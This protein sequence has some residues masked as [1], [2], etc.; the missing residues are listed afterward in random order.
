VLAKFTTKFLR[1]MGL[2]FIFFFAIFCIFGSLFLRD[3][4]DT[5]FLSK[6]LEYT[7]SFESRFYDY[8]MREQLNRKA[9]SKDVALIKI[10]DASLEKIGM[11][12]I[13]RSIHADMI[14][15]LGAFGAKVVA[16]D[17]LYPEKAPVCGPVSPDDILAEA[18]SNF[19][20]DGGKVFLAYTTGTSVEDSLPEAPVEMLNDTVVTRSSSDVNMHAYQIGR[21]TFP[22]QKFVEADVGLGSIS[23]SEDPD[24]IFRHYL[25]ILNVDTIYFGSLGFNSWEAF[26][27]KK[28]EVKIF[29][30]GTGELELDD[31]RL[32][33]NNRGETKIRWFGNVENFANVSL[34]ELLN[35]KDDDVAMKEALGNKIV[36]VGSTALGA[37]DL[38]ASPIDS[39]M[40][41]VLAHM[42]MAHMLLNRYFYQ[43][44]NESV[45]YSLIILCVGMLI[46]LL[47]QR[48]GSA[49]LDIFVLILLI[50]ASFAA[51]YYYFLPQGYELKLFYCFFCFIASY[52]WNTFLQFSDASKEKKQIKGTFAR[53]VA[54]TIVDEM[55]KDPDKLQV[56]GF[57]RDITCLFSDVRDFTSISESLGAAE[58]AHSLNLY[59]GKM[60]DIVFETKGTLDKYIG[61]AIVAFWGAPLEIGNHA[62]YAVEGAIKMI[63]ALPKVNEEFAKLGRPLFKVG[64]GL[65]SGE[66]NVGNMGSDRIFSYTA[67]GDNMNLGA[68]LEGLCKYYGSQILISEYTLSRI[69]QQKIIVRPID[70]VIVKGKTTPVGVFEVLHGWHPVSQN[71]EALNFYQTA[72]DLFTKREFKQALD[73]FE[74]LLM[75]L[76]EDIPTKRL[77]DL[78]KKYVEQ[79]E[80]ADQYFDVTKMTEK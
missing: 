69:D 77:R 41:G 40:P 61:D 45:K 60:T 68:R 9:I 63:E 62:Q 8:R 38:R 58:L 49:F 72:H 3:I 71:Q 19:Q 22:I 17:I 21:Y 57:K 44:S 79:P 65:N 7:I 37:H 10:D 56:G 67:L 76:P 1:S 15:K 59:M 14:N 51:D 52:S 33:L 50:A 70:K 20:Q 25:M 13:P 29:N 12:P 26:T 6:F 34:H 5:T 27:E 18:F 43:P 35:A 32:E 73:I 48:L 78:C 46:F 31:K 2:A 42:N 30:D 53:Y 80:A 24:G 39:K 47:I 4:D 28:H 11:W 54:P 55:L 36:F 23:M 66:C 64:I 74:Q 75:A 16:L